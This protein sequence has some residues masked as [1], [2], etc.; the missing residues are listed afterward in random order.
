MDTQTIG[1]ITLFQLADLWARLIG[2]L[3]LFIGALIIVVVGLFAASILKFATEAI[4]RGVKL[5]ELLKRGGVDK[6]LEKA[7]M[8]L[9]S[10]A[11]FGFIV[12]WFFVLVTIFAVSDVLGLFGLTLFLNGVLAYVLNNVVVAIL[13]LLATIL[14]ANFLRD[15]VVTAARGARLHGSRFVGLI[16]WWAVI[17]F[18]IGA[19]F[20]QLNVAQAF[21]NLVNYAV[22]GVILMFAVAGGIAFGLGGKDYAAHLLGRVREHTEER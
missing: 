18:G 8:R 17:L 10:A 16:T 2:F 6:K 22:L 1:S 19:T 13:I 15:A 5:D 11:F 14:I 7:G 9:N 20:D 3:P 4:V 12:Y 21:V